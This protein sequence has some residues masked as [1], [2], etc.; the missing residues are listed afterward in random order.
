[1]E[2]LTKSSVRRIQDWKQEWSGMRQ[3]VMQWMHIISARREERNSS[4]F[5]LSYYTMM[6]VAKVCSNLPMVRMNDDTILDERNVIEVTMEDG[7]GY[8]WNMKMKVNDKVYNVYAKFTNPSGR[9]ESMV[10]EGVQV[11]LGGIMAK[12]N[13]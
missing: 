12:V 6:N 4:S 11:N 8:S 1:M 3:R 2:C 13:L 7:S 10:I 9:L 5:F